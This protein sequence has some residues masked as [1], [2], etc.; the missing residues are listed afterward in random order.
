MN[1]HGLVKKSKRQILLNFLLTQHPRSHQSFAIRQ[2]TPLS[3]QCSLTFR[4]SCLYRDLQLPNKL[5]DDALHLIAL[6][7]IETW[8]LNWFRSPERHRGRAKINESRHFRID[9]HLFANKSQFQD[10]NPAFIGPSLVGQAKSQPARGLDLVSVNPEANSKVRMQFICRKWYGW[11]LVE[12]C[13]HFCNRWNFLFAEF[14]DPMGT[15]GRTL[16]IFECTDD[17]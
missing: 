6:H 5:S 17:L 12:W 3:R 8:S 13:L 16:W 15:D 10:P 9:Q 2:L 4:T 11:G 1:G 14:W 7:L